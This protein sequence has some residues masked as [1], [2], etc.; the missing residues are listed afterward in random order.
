[1][2]SVTKILSFIAA[3]IFLFLGVVP[4]SSGYNGS[5]IVCLSLFLIFGFSFVIMERKVEGSNH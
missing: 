4:T 1:M 5:H 3:V 2:R